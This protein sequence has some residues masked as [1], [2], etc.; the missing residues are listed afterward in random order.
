MSQ[1]NF[2]KQFGHDELHE[3]HGKPKHELRTIEVML[4]N[5]AS[6]EPCFCFRISMDVHVSGKYFINSVHDAED[7]TREFRAD[8]VLNYLPQP[9]QFFEWCE[10][11]RRLDHWNRAHMLKIDQRQKERL[12]AT[13][14]DPKPM[15]ITSFKTTNCSLECATGSNKLM[16]TTGGVTTTRMGFLR[17]EEAKEIRDGVWRLVINGQIIDVAANSEADARYLAHQYLT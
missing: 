4:L 1:T 14:E 9:L 10:H 16:F 11:P 7:P 8:Q 3:T 6:C 13:V 5:E 2:W 12:H 17:T 15:D